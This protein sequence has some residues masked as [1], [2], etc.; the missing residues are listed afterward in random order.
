MNQTEIIQEEMI[1][2]EKGCVDLCS[3]L[4][5]I[6]SKRIPWRY[7][8]KGI[9]HM[10]F[11]WNYH[12]LN[13][14][15][16]NWDER[17]AA[18]MEG[19]V[20]FPGLLEGRTILTSYDFRLEKVSCPSLPDV[21]RLEILPPGT[22]CP[23]DFC[24]SV[25]S[26]RVC[27]SDH[28]LSVC[29]EASAASPRRGNSIHSGLLLSSSPASVNPRYGCHLVFF[30]KKSLL[31]LLSW[32]LPEFSLPVR[33]KSIPT[34]YTRLTFR[35]NWSSLYYM[36][37]IHWNSVLGFPLRKVSCPE[38]CLPIVDAQIKIQNIDWKSKMS[39]NIRSTVGKQPIFE[40]S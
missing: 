5:I 37:F 22:L 19:T 29:V 10:T 18:W 40:S 30:S 38:N 21:P 14:L 9:V 32:C 12:D 16:E 24:A 2:L 17:I 4:E 13:L 7:G 20:I 15:L 1:I 28:Y 34:L 26:C 27:V 36:C 39:K 8:A 6:E 3:L 33:L 35:F 11:F 31:M 23:F 25:V